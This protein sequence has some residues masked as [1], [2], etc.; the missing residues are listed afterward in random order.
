MKSYAIIDKDLERTSAVGYLFYYEK[1]QS[2]VIELC[3]DLDEW[4]APLLFQGMVKKNI[5]TIPKEF[6]LMW[7]QERIIPSGRQN[8]NSILKNHGLNEYS[9][10]AMLELSGGKCCQDKCY[11]EEISKEKIPEDIRKRLLKHDF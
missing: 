6:S 8:I 11:I 2:F 1:S 9:E 4:E 7:V 5:F 3:E 10:I